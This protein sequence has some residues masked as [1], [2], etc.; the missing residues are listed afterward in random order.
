MTQDTTETPA[1]GFADRDAVARYTDG[2]RR[3]VPGHDSLLV[4]TDLLLAEKLADQGR[5]FVLGAGGGMEMAHF[6]RN[7]PGWR[8][9]GVDPSAAMLELAVKTMGPTAE[10]AELICGYVDDAP[11][12][13]FDAATCLLTLHFIPAVERLATLKAI[14]ARLRSG[15]PFVCAHHSV[16]DDADQRALWFTRFAAFAERSGVPPETARNAGARIGAALPILSPAEDGSLL[17]AAGFA[18]V[19]QFYAAF[20]FRG[21]VCEA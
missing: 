8:F 11:M 12:G 21:W 3:L 9:V 5:V 20:T 14:R 1:H 6:A 2:P 16:P 17:Y 18:K 15:A 19:Q 13:P 7:H 4:M 10:R